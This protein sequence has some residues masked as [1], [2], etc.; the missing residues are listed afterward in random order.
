MVYRQVGVQVRRYF[1]YNY[2]GD[3]SRSVMESFKSLGSDGSS[4]KIRS[5]LLILCDRRKRPH[6]IKVRKPSTSVENY[7]V[8]DTT[9]RTGVPKYYQ[10]VGSR[11]GRSVFGPRY[12]R[13]T[14]YRSVSVSVIRH[15]KP[16]ERHFLDTRNK[17][18]TVNV[19]FSV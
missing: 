3:N 13:Q 2:S 18:R 1:I 16:S 12:L 4:S 5:T 11:V 7:G 17:Y 14:G 10:L 15:T 8:Y 19:S 6:K 9:T